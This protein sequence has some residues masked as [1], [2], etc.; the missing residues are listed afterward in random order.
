M[1]PAIA[2]TLGGLVIAWTLGP[3]EGSAIR[4][5]QLLGNAHLGSA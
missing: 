5:R 1:Y 4:I 2:A 3:P